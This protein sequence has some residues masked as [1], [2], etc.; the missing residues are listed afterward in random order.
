M[1]QSSTREYDGIEMHDGH[2]AINVKVYARINLPEEHD[3]FSDQAWE[4][5]CSQ[6]WEEARD[7]ARDSGYDY[8]FAEGRSGGWL[9]PFRQR[10]ARAANLYS[11]PGQGGQWGYP[12][13]PDMDSIGERSRFRAF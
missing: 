13:Y 11:S 12:Q 6:F 8:I 9:V 5:V 1:A 2:A 3:Q 7:V 4:S 10:A